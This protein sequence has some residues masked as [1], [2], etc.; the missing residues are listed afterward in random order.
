MSN[1]WNDN[2]FKGNECE[3]IFNSMIDETPGWK[4]IKYGVENH[5][6]S[7]KNILKD[8]KD[9]NSFQIRSMPDFIVCNQKEHKAF[10]IDVK[11]QGFVDMRTPRRIIFQ[12]PYCKIKNYIEFWKSSYI[13]IMHHH[14]P[15]FYLIPVEK[16]QWHKH[17]RG[18][19]EERDQFREVWDFSGILMDIKELIPALTDKTIQKA[20][21]RIPPKESTSN[22]KESIR[23]APTGNRT[24][25]PALA[26]PHCT[27]QLPAR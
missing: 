22:Y 20:I 8:N 6:D 17:F 23:Y 24:P 3:N 26:R 25:A 21:K 16:I 12:F 9:A 14:S 27:I 2:K 1:N 18:R 15:H 13:L 10:I 5:I 11:Y 7:L 4:C 19:T